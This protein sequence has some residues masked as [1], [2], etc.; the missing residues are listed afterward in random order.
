[1]EHGAEAAP[2]A[3]F[4]G[5]AS[6]SQISSKNLEGELSPP[7]FFRHLSGGRLPHRDF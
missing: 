4:G 5:G 2:A 1:M 3:F 6:P 7:N